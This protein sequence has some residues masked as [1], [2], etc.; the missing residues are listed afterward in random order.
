[1]QITHPAGT[2][3][4]EVIVADIIKSPE[5]KDDGVIATA[6]PENLRLLRRYFFAH[7]NGD[8]SLQFEVSCSNEACGRRAGGSRINGTVAVLGG[9]SGGNVDVHL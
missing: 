8:R 4:T 5:A 9:T 6:S 7:K 3:L 2:V 1:M